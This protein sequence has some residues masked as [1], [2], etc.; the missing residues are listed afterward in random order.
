MKLAGKVALVTGS[1]RGI[2][3]GIAVEMAR[4]GADVTVN[5]NTHEGEAQDVAHEIQK[6][7]RRVIVCQADVSRRD[8]VDRMVEATLQAFGKVDICVN[9]AASTVRKPF[10]ELSGDEFQ[11]VLDVSLMSVFHTSQACAREMVKRGQGGAILIISS[12]HAF[13]PFRTSVAYNACKA[14][15]NHM[16]HTMAEE[17]LQHKI[18]VNVIEPGW[19][20]TPGERRFVPE[21]KIQAMGKKLPWRRLGTIEEIG[22]AAVFLC[23]ADADYIT[24]ACLRVDGGFWLPARSADSS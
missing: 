24:A 8:A 14:G 15:I 23:S 10:L 9:N 7:G 11:W 6:L 13:I 16:G 2:G 21:D 5:Y 1:N 12:V 4:E 17:L 3:R 19:I 20:D 22:K 18:R